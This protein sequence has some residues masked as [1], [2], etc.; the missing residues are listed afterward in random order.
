MAD[1]RLT[2]EFTPAVPMPTAATPTTATEPPIAPPTHHGV[3]GS[4]G[5]PSLSWE[6]V[7]EQAPSNMLPSLGQQFKNLYQAVRH[8]VETGKALGGIA[9]GGIQSLIPG[10]QDYESNWESFVD[11]LVERY[12]SVD[13]FKRT[14]ATDPAGVMIDLSSIVFPAAQ[15]A[16]LPRMAK[17]ASMLDPVSATLTVARK[18]GGAIIPKW[19]PSLFYESAIK[20]SKTIPK[21]QRVK[22]V[23]K[24][25]EKQIMPMYRGLYKLDTLIKSLDTKVNDI[26]D[27]SFN[28]NRQI[29]IDD[30][31]K[32][33]NKLRDQIKRTSSEPLKGARV[34]TAVENEIRKANKQ[35]G[36]TTLTLKEAQ[37]MKQQIYK[38]MEKE[39]KR[40]GHSPVRAEARVAVARNLKLAIEEIV[41]EVKKLNKEEGVMIALHKELSDTAQNIRKRDFL[42]IGTTV[43]AAGGGAMFG[44]GG[45]LVGLTLGLLDSQPLLKAK[46]GLVMHRLKEKGIRVRPTLLGTRLGLYQA[47]RIEPEPELSTTFQPQS[48]RP[49]VNGPETILQSP[50][51]D[52]I[53]TGPG[54]HVFKP[55]P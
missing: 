4:F 21:R 7:F 40:I 51:G 26:I 31:F 45:A 17:V 12:G 35:L 46:L 30:L 39:Y 29:P 11:G 20:M 27:K 16:R 25:L 2:T 41:P 44:P 55:K 33:F 49:F 43:K 6:E 42:T 50:R 38:E 53:M 15:T 28:V 5:E 9:A 14:L 3:S 18:T 47:G 23:N 19:V 13:A 24:A 36:R 32:D 52:H 48:Y 8:P 10:E 22:L 1:N 34:F 37:T 54:E